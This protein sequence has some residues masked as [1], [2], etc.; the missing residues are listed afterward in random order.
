L[1]GFETHPRVTSGV[2]HERSLLRG[3][4]DV[5]I[6]G[7][8]RKGEEFVPIILSF[9]H[10]G[11]EVLLQFLVGTFGLSIGLGVIGGGCRELYSKESVQFAC[12]IGDEL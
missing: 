2:D 9:V 6:V 1:L 5:I 11:S 8:L 7:E 10:E 3:R 12:K 4:V